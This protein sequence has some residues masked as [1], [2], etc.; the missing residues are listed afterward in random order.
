MPRPP[1]LRAPFLARDERSRDL[2]L[3]KVEFLLLG[4]FDQVVEIEATPL[5]PELDRGFG[6]DMRVLAMHQD[7]FV[8]TPDRTG[9]ILGFVERHAQRIRTHEVTDDGFA[10][11]SVT[12]K[13]PRRADDVAAL[14]PSR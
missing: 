7:R 3:A 4:R 14:T 13:I 9:E 12:M 10:A 11:R 6:R 2:D 5:G 1:C 8:A